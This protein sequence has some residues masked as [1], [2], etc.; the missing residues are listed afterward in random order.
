MRGWPWPDL[1]PH[2]CTPEVGLV[3]GSGV[4][5]TAVSGPWPEAAEAAQPGSGVG[6]K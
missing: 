3:S 6:Q 4:S 1:S 2:H 5:L